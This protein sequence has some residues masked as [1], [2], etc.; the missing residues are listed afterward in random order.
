MQGQPSFRTTT[1]HGLP[2]ARAGLLPTEGTKR[3][4]GAH[5]PGRQEVKQQMQQQSQVQLHEM[6]LRQLQQQRRQQQQQKQQQQRRVSSASALRSRSSIFSVNSTLSVDDMLTEFCSDETENR[7]VPLADH[8]PHSLTQR[9]NDVFQTQVR[10]MSSCL[11]PTRKRSSLHDLQQSL[12]EDLDDN[13]RFETAL[14]TL[15]QT[16]QA[17]GNTIS[18]KCTLP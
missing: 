2:L 5:G 9:Q 11:D 1:A 17:W 14:T 12:R 7:L 15:S 3:N 4:L 13:V 8:T 6:Q 18:M 10:R 16:L